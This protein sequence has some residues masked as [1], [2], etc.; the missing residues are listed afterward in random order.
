MKAN[1]S[2]AKSVVDLVPVLKDLSNNQEDNS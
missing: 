1:E 2:L